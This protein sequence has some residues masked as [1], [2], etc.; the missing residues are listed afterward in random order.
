MVGLNE[1][2]LV[3]SAFLPRTSLAGLLLSASA[4]VVPNPFG[5]SSD[6]STETTDG[7]SSESESS[8]GDGDGDPMG[9]GDGEPGGDGDGGPGGDGDGDAVPEECVV[10]GFEVA[11][12]ITIDNSAGPFANAYTLSLELDTASLIQAGTLSADCSDL[13]F[14]DELGGPLGFAVDASTCNTASTQLYK[15]W[16]KINHGLK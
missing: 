12:R 14:T 6:L 3:L 16:L 2:I 9:D 15:S 13:R 11:R 5:D 4:C 7:S 1:E 10:E 8:G